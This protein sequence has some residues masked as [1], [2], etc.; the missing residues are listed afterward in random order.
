MAKS[1]LQTELQNKQPFDCPEQ[2]ATLNLLRT[3][4]FLA[5]DAAALF[6]RHGISTSQFNVLRIL[7]GQRGSGLP[8]QEIVAQMVTQ[9]PDITRLVDRLEAAGL[10]I[11]AR[12]A[13]DRRVV[14]VHIT[15]Q[16]LALLARLD[17]PVL[18]LHRHQMNHLTPAEIAELNRLLVTLRQPPVAAPP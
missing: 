4:D 5:R 9:T 1:V 12:T 7:R 2:E 17:A 15:Q 16:G 8:C 11:R 10:A 6:E 3:A 13:A 14:L 18:D